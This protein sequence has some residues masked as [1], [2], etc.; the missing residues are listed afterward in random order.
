V[1]RVVRQ[2]SVVRVLVEVRWFARDVARI[3]RVARVEVG[4]KRSSAAVRI[5]R[6][7]WLDGA[8]T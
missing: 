2:V 5:A 1:E 7:L 4:S 6:G 3:G 8:G